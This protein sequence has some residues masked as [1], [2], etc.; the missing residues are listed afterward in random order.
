MFVS[1]FHSNNAIYNDIHQHRDF[2]SYMILL[3]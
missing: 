3:N 2:V 1:V